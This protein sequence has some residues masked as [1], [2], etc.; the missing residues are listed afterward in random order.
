MACPLD[1][2]SGHGHVTALSNALVKFGATTR[3]AMDMAG[4]AGEADTVDLFTKG[5]RGADKFLWMVEAHLQ[6][7]D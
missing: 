1:L 7:K 3:A 6:S 2:A 5:F 4:K